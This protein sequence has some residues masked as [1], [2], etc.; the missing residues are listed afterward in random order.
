M[1]T[2]LSDLAS[3]LKS[4][5]HFCTYQSLF[6]SL[7]DAGEIA[8]I[9]GSSLALLLSLS[10]NFNAPRAIIVPTLA[11]A[12]A[13]H[14]DFSG[15]GVKTLSFRSPQTNIYSPTQMKQGLIDQIFEIP[16]FSTYIIPLRT[17]LKKLPPV[18]YF[19]KSQILLKTG[20]LLNLVEIG[21]SLSD[22]GYLRT[23]RVSMPGEYAIRG[24][25][26]D[27]FLHGNKLAHRIQVEFD[28]ISEIRLFDPENQMSHTHT[29]KLY[30]IPAREAILNDENMDIILEKIYQKTPKIPITKEEFA[31]LSHY[32]ELFLPYLFEKHHSLAHYLPKDT[33]FIFTEFERLEQQNSQFHYELTEL[34][35]HAIRQNL[36]VPMPHDLYF[37]FDQIQNQTHQI[38]LKNID[39][40]NDAYPA[41]KVEGARSFFGNMDLLRHEMEELLR[42]GYHIFIFAET[43]QQATRIEHL[44][45]N[46]ALVIVPYGLS[47]GF[48]LPDSK[49]MFICE[50]EIFGRKKRASTATSK[51]TPSQALDSFIDLSP[52]DY[53]VHINHGIGQFK[54]IDRLRTS[55][56]ERDYIVLEF[57]DKDIIYVPIEQV[58]MVQRYIGN[59]G[60]TPK[61]DRIGSKSWNQ[62][63]AYAQKSAEELADYLIDLYAKREASEGFV[64]PPD[65]EFQLE[66]EADFPHQ[67]TPDQLTTIVEIKNDMQM[68]RPMDRLVCG[69]VGYGKTELAMRAAFK[70]AMAGKQIIMLCPTTI[71]AEQHYKNFLTRFARFSFIKIELLSRFVER[72]KQK[73][74]IEKLAKGEV[75][76]LIGTH[77]VLSA[78]IEFRDLGLLIID[79]EQRFGVKDKEKIRNLKANIDTLV[80]SATPIPRTLHMSLVKI[81]D[82]STLKTPPANR[83]AIETFVEELNNERIA[84]A[85]RTEIQRAGQIFYLHNRVQTLE[86][87]KIFL[88]S[89][90]PEAMI[91][92]AHGQ[93]SAHEL[94]DVMYRFIHGEFQVLVST[95]I[96]ESGIDIPNVN[97]IIIDRADMYGVSQLY[98]LRGRVGRSDRVAYAYLFYPSQQALSD[99]AI[100]RLE[101]ISDFTQLG[102]GF[103]IAMKDMEVR[104][105]G[106]LLGRDQS[107]HIQAI[108]FDLYLRLLNNAIDLKTSNSKEIMV[109]P[110]LELEYSGFIPDEYIP[111]IVQK[112]EIYKKIASVY[113]EEEVIILFNEIADRFGP[114]PD[115]V[116]SLISLAE[117]RCLCRRLKINSLKERNGHVQVEFGKLAELSMDNLIRM[118][119]ESGGVIRPDH[120][121]QTAI[122]VETGKI[123][124]KEKSEF[125]RDQLARL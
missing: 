101:I 19:S 87:T 8:G 78:D 15:F 68:A 89:L 119:Q 5:P 56:Q 25:I 22:M 27:I 113:D 67:E 116:V 54:S 23:P 72:K 90:V 26:L 37:K 80:L 14:S 57:A 111:N 98:Q 28:E 21:Q 18:D 42:L 105:T 20:A 85:I 104:G 33:Q 74:I 11:D 107:G 49:I 43:Q 13:M 79:E 10:N 69:D 81:R 62:K 84:Q 121:N 29:D 97:T 76:I 123:G 103:K 88:Q 96:I 86:A 124:L 65:D 73:T 60:A 114:I 32:H 91:D 92:M 53:I 9:K 12:Q 125:L 1:Q 94:E 115:E 4:D 50:H 100:K 77:R 102:D 45:L 110:Y 117:L 93:M 52:G 40:R 75:D 82:L 24:E 2:W 3:R 6:A 39:K 112:M 44:F 122:L 46:L 64:Y 7:T 51:S 70:A 55:G 48:C 59:E 118:I 71:L 34:Y 83:Q 47:S 38:I 58:N 16:H 41:L 108:G 95:T 66:F 17:L 109:D 120:T 106:N 30:L 99:L 63:K 31:Q 36:P 61:L 35:K